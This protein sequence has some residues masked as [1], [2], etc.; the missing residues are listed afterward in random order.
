MDSSQVKASNGPVN[1]YLPIMAKPRVVTVYLPIM[2]KPRV[3]TVF[4]A[5]LDDN[6]LAQMSAAGASWVHI[7]FDWSRV[8]AFEG[9]QLAWQNVDGLEEELKAVSNSYI[10]AILYINDTPTWALKAGYPCG[11]VAQDKFGDLASFL[12]DLVKRYS[13]PPFNVKYYEL[14]SEPDVSGLLGCWGDPRDLDYYGGRYYGEMLKWAYSAI[15]T[16]DS[17]AQVLFGGL[18]M[19][20]NPDHIEYCGGDPAVKTSI[21]HFLEGALVDGAGSD[22]DGISFH[23]YDYYGGGLGQYSNSNWGTAWNTTGPVSVAKAAYLRNLLAQYNVTGKYLINTELAILCGRDGTEA[24]CVTDDH[25]Q[26]VSAYIVQAYAT[27]MAD[28][29]RSMVWYSVA[30][31][32]GSG[33]VDANLTPLPPYNAYKNARV[34]LGGA[35]Y[36]GPITEFTGIKGYEF[37]NNGLRI[38]VLWSVTG[39][40]N[41]LTIALGTM[42]LAVYDTYGAALPVGMTLNVGLEPVFIVFGP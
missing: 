33:L 25:E 34:W 27:G 32:R 40:G 12:T 17:Q 8:E 35:A 31:W 7:P 38:W 19:D 11:A 36:I 5:F 6:G 4:G 1:V 26:T 18:L 15:K 37:S 39:V 16:A 13:V 42:P 9:Q 21:A 22:F 23:A 2:A 41:P 14:W 24:P 28:G 30:G 10:N 20:C 29:L 3:V